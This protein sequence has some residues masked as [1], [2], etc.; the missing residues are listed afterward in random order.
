M[1]RS[2]DARFPDA[3]WVRIYLPSN[4]EPLYKVQVHQR[5]ESRAWLRKTLVSI[6][7]TGARVVGSY[8]ALQAPLLDRLLDAAYPLH[9]G[10]IVGWPGRILILVSGAILPVMFITDLLAWRGKRKRRSKRSMAC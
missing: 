4:A 6:D 5:G 3:Q 10:E 2:D 7:A 9:N 8:D 1:P